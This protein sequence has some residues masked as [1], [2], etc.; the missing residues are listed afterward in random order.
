M[1]EYDILAENRIGGAVPRRN[2]IVSLYQTVQKT[3]GL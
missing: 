3:C 2:A 1:Y